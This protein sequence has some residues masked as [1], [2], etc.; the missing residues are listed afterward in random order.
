MNGEPCKTCN[1]SGM[2]NGVSGYPCP[3]CSPSENLT[4]EVT[5]EAIRQ[6]HEEVMGGGRRCEKCD[7]QM[8]HYRL[9][10]YRCVRCD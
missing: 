5:R 2:P 7:G 10:G 3:E 1:G 4:Q 6:L 9:K 8:A